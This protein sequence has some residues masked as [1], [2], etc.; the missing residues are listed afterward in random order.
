MKVGNVL[1][2]I[3]FDERSCHYFLCP[4]YKDT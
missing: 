1:S 2:L 4:F 3:V